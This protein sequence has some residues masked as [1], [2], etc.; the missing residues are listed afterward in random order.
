MTFPQ[1]ALPPHSSLWLKDFLIFVF[2]NSLW[3]FLLLICQI[4]LGLSASA[5][6]RGNEFGNLMI[7]AVRKSSLSSVLK[8]WLEISHDV[9]SFLYFE[10]QNSLFIPFMPLRTLQNSNKSLS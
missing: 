5:A 4:L 3:T 10:V 6:F 8:L 9:P 2:D 1:Y 7:H